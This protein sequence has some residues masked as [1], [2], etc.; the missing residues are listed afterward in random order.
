MSLS[1]HRDLSLVKSEGFHSK[2]PN[3]RTFGSSRKCI[4]EGDGHSMKEEKQFYQRMLLSD[5]EVVFESKLL[6]KIT[7]LSSAPINIPWMHPS[8][9]TMEEKAGRGGYQN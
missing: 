4:S 7:M 1:T 2:Y 3:T 8:T 5:K 9:A 6:G